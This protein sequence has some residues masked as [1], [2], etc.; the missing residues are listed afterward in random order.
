MEAF[1]CDFGIFVVSAAVALADV[2]CRTPFLYTIFFFLIY[3]LILAV[4]LDIF[5][6]HLCYV[7]FICFAVQKMAKNNLFF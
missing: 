6:S 7:F 5:L 3:I 2:V 4:W 1:R